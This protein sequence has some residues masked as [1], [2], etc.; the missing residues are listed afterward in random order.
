MKTFTK[1][2]FNKNLAQTVQAIHSG[3][4]KNKLQIKETTNL[5]TIHSLYI[6]LLIKE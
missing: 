2:S 3:D 1:N 5:S 4:T 6:G